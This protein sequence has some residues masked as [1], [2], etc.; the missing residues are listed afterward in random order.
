M[1]KMKHIFHS[2]FFK[3]YFASILDE[4]PDEFRGIL[5]FSKFLDICAA[6]VQRNC[7]FRRANDDLDARSWYS[8]PGLL[9]FN[10]SVHLVRLPSGQVV[11]RKNIL[12]HL[13]SDATNPFTRQP[14]AE[15]ELVSGAF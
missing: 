7:S 8:Q 14:L 15:A 4:I 10:Y 12:R 3:T 13:L 1:L 6:T 5:D 2:K 11:D 9:N